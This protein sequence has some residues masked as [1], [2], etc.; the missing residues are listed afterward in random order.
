MDDKLFNNSDEAI[1]FIINLN[2]NMILKNKEHIKK[3]YKIRNIHSSVLDSMDNYMN[4]NHNLISVY[5]DSIAVDILRETKYMD[6][7][8]D[9]HNRDDAEV[10]NELVIYKN[11]NKLKS[12]TEVF[13][14]NKKLKNPD[15]VKM[16]HAMN[17]SIVGLFKVIDYDFKEGYVTYLDVFTKKK[18]KI[19]DISMSSLEML[20]KDKE[21][22]IYNRII[23]YDGI[24][25]GTGLPIGMIGSNKE[26]K[27]FIKHHNYKTCSSFS[28]CLML[29]DI[30]KKDISNST[31]YYN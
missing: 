4:K 13:I 16:L 11:H 31:I 1:E 24:S 8:L 25:F 28:R 29:Y 18:Y 23:T 27:D 2:K 20:Y 7:E 6:I 30:A 17:K 9:A 10:F 26:L 14:E 22:Y 21:I 19:I 15:K 5:L 3:Y 12:I